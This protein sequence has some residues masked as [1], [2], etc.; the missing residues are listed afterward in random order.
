MGN[1]YNLGFFFPIILCVNNFCS[2][3][4]SASLQRGSTMEIKEKKLKTE[5]VLSAISV[6]LP[7]LRTKGNMIW[8]KAQCS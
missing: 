6:I 5:N 1:N 2:Y 3:L 7:S 8:L 4:S